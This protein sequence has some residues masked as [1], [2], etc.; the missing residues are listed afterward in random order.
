[1]NR[2]LNGLLK[3]AQIIHEN[4]ASTK[5]GQL[6]LVLQ[7]GGKSLVNETLRSC[8]FILLIINFKC[9]HV[10]AFNI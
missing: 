5:T 1:M 8:L 3:Q 7:K 6:K 4:W 10:V 2:L 9:V